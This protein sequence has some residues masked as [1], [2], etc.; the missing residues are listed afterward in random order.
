M[1]REVINIDYKAIWKTVRIGIRRT[2]LFLGLGLNAIKDPDF[3]DYKL[4]SWGTINFLPDE[5][6]EETISLY[7]EEFSIWIIGCGLRELFETFSIFLNQICE[8]SLHVAVH[9][10]HNIRPE[11]SKKLFRVVTF[12]G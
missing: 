7:K 3:K 10:Q 5:A 12:E 2:N 8:A 1:Q 4:P 6:A 11:K 9:L